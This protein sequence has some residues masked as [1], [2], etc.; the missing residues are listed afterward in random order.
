MFEQSDNFQEFATQTPSSARFKIDPTGLQQHDMEPDNRIKNVVDVILQGAKTETP[1]QVQALKLTVFDECSTIIAKPWIMKGLF[2]RGET[3]SWIAPPGAGKSAVLTC[4]AVHVAAHKDWRGFRSKEH[5][6]VLYLAFERADLVKRRLSVYA[7]RGFAEL[8]IA[9]ADQIINLMSPN[10]VDIILATIG[11]AEEQLGIKIGLIIIDTYAKGIAIGGGDEDKAKDQGRC[12]A[13]LRRVQEATNVHIAII[14]HTGKDESRGGRCSNA[15][16]ADTD[17]QVQISRDGAV[18]TA[19][20]IK[21]NDQPCGLLLQFTMRSEAMGIDDDGDEISV[22]ILSDD[23]IK[24]PPKSASWPKSLTQLFDA[25]TT[26]SLDDGFDH[27]PGNDGPLVRAVHLDKVRGI[28][29]RN[30]VGS[31]DSKD[32]GGA[33][34]K[35]LGR[36]LKQARDGRLIGGEEILGRQIIWTARGE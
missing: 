17:V 1:S 16:Q 21:G 29:R 35:A 2:A 15:H 8:P 36:A 7:K 25:I 27:R 31:A 12:L 24:V 6:A 5:C 30:Y 11:K 33:A 34:D 28:Y 19:K 10:C 23:E 3:S 14:G 9:I 26:T 18:K 32:R 4:A 20:V 22:G 13:N